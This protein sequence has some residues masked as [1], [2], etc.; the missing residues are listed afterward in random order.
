M[1]RPPFVPAPDGGEEESP[2]TLQRPRWIV[3]R[4]G[5]EV[6]F[7]PGRI[8][9]AVRRAQDEVGEHD[10]LFADEVADV[11]SLTIGSRALSAAGGLAHA[12]PVPRVEEVGDL[13]EDVLV[14]MGRT[15]LAK[16]T[17]LYRERRA[18]AREALTILE[19]P[20]R[21]GRA[22]WVRDGAGTSPWNA[23]RIVAALMEEADLPREL[24]EEVAERVEGRVVD[25]GLR[26]LSTSLIREFV[27]NELMGM[28][29]ETALHRQEPVGVPRHDLRRLL[30]RRPRD[31]WPPDGDDTREEGELEAAVAGTVLERYGL[32]DVLEERTADLH[33]AGAIDVV[34]LRR[35]QRVLSRAL[36][37]ELFVRGEPSARSPFELLESLAPIAAGASRAVVLERL[38]PILAPLARGA[39]G[40]AALRDWLLALGALARAAGVRIDL[41]HPGGRGGSFLARLLSE[42]APLDVEGHALPRLFLSWD[43]LAPALE[44]RGAADAAEQL[45]ARGALVPVWHAPEERWVAPG[46]RRGPRE[47]G[48]LACAGAVALNLPRLARQAGPWREDVFCEALAARLLGALDALQSLDAFQRRQP[49]ARAGDL[50][51][52][53]VFAIVPV[54]LSEALRI[55]GDGEVRPAQ[56]ARLL[57]VLAEATQRFAQER[58][59][60]VSVSPFFGER[61][62]ARFAR[63]DA[64]GP[65]ERQARLFADL[66]APEEQRDA[67]Y[68][69]GYVL[70]GARAGEDPARF[71]AEQAALCA[72]LRTGALVGFGL[73]GAGSAA[74]APH[75]SLEA[76]RS[77]HEHR[78]AAGEREPHAGRRATAA[79]T[80]SPPG[81][82]ALERAAPRPDD[83]HAGP[84]FLP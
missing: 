40:S 46:C 51:E 77:F 64:R 73:S 37:A 24:A 71:G 41:A 27:D 8:A 69:V 43:E 11:V 50:R 30:G 3:K 59:L 6:P 25:A 60:S 19:R 54:G 63:Q 72:T 56:G 23:A 9:A 12:P 55:L 49:A 36:P 42:L 79:R 28:G 15:A 33:K 45:C 5:R 32:A 68:G 83:P 76:W 1:A 22:P 80:S 26:R 20:E 35:P 44:E 47:R 38:Q 82:R 10:P 34:D 52:R 74:F 53:S 13:I 66:P 84:L 57:G 29:L 78:F 4:D 65:R 81:A 21:A 18:R 75:P 7:D 70:S 58:G 17:I 67:P 61:S 16:A 39:R 48:A 2:A 14:Q 31:P 62:R